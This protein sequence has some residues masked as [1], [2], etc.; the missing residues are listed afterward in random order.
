MIHCCKDKKAVLPAGDATWLSGF[1]VCFIALVK[2]FP[3]N[4]ETFA[5][6]CPGYS[7]FFTSVQ[8]DRAELQKVGL[9]TLFLWWRRSSVTVCEACCPRLSTRGGSW[10]RGRHHCRFKRPQGYSGDCLGEQRRQYFPVHLCSR[11][12]G[13]SHR[14]CDLCRAADSQKPFH[15][16][17]LRG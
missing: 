12:R 8:T 15:C 10:R 7:Q 14:L 11:S 13:T 6:L 9:Q 16:P 2:Y 5:V 17:H 3:R 4:V 1:P